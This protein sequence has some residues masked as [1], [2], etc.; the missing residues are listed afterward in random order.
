[1]CKPAS[2][3]TVVA[4]RSGIVLIIVTAGVPEDSDRNT[5]VAGGELGAVP[6]AGEWCGVERCG[7]PA[8]Q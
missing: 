5:A 6:D 1:M 4:A 2:A 3:A 8:R 7:P